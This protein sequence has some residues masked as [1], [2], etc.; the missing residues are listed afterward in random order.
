M[1]N[2]IVERKVVNQEPTFSRNIKNGQEVGRWWQKNNKKKVVMQVGV[3]FKN[4]RHG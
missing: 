4:D 1:L 3:D 2:D